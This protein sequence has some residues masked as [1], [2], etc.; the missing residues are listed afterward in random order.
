MFD[1]FLSVFN[2]KKRSRVEGFS[3]DR[4]SVMLND[5]SISGPSM[6]KVGPKVRFSSK[7]NAYSCSIL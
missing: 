6:G 5:R 3:S 2:V 1:E 7:L 4:S